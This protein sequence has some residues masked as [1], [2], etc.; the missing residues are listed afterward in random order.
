[1]GV[2][3]A[4]G[5]SMA[6]TAPQKGLSEFGAPISATGLSLKGSIDMN[7]PSAVNTQTG[8]MIVNGQVAGRSSK[9]VDP[10]QKGGQNVAGINEFKQKVNMML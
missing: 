3:N 6:Q 2:A 5:G 10:H 8:T 7:L 1:M 4:P 9:R